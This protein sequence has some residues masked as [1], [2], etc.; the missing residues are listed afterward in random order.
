M[1]NAAIRPSEGIRRSRGSVDDL[2]GNGASLVAVMTGRRFGLIEKVAVTRGSASGGQAQDAHPIGFVAFLV[3]PA[4]TT[5]L[6]VTAMTLL[7][8]D[9]ASWPITT[10][11]RKTNT[12]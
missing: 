2:Q 7:L 6:G 4:G 11:A 1:N 8:L 5:T 9:R 3:L 12:V 10:E